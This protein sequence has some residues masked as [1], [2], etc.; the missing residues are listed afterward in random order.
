MNAQETLES[1]EIAATIG[2]RMRAAR[3]ALNLSQL[4][5]ARQLGYANSSKLAK[6]EGGMGDWGRASRNVQLWVI[7]RAA[8]LYGVSAD[9]LFGLCD[10]PAGLEWIETQELDEVCHDLIRNE[11]CREA[12]AR[13]LIVLAAGLQRAS[14][15][16]AG[17][18]SAVGQMSQAMRLVEQNETWQDARGGSRLAS[19]CERVTTTVRTAGPH[20]HRA[21]PTARQL[22]LEL[23]KIP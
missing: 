22:R 14:D 2:Q 11:E 12:K 20:I 10:N 6:I 3:Q 19:A 16:M 13:E 15:L 9:Y 18:S 8:C 5:A 17:I 21:R 7:E 4:N 23:R 1:I